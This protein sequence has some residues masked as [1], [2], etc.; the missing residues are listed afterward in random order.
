MEDDEMSL[1]CGMCGKEEKFIQS[2]S[3]ENWEQEASR[4]H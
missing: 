2:V 1:T 4:E 3:T